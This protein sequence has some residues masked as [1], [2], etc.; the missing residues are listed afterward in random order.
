[1]LWTLTGK[2]RLICS[3]LLPNTVLFGA[4]DW[5]TQC[6]MPELVNLN[7]AFYFR[8]QESEENFIN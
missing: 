4:S 8:N 7:L 6:D 1:M 3:F 2:R 5:F